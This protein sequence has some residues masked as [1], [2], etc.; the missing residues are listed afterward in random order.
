MSKDEETKFLGYSRLVHKTR[1]VVIL[2]DKDG[3]QVMFQMGN[4][5]LYNLMAYI[6]TQKINLRCIISSCISITHIVSHNESKYAE[7]VQR[8]FKVSRRS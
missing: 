5:G 8:M 6:S 4:E 7:S 3:A 2:E 1:H